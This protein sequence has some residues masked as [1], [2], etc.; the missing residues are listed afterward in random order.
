[1]DK[2]KVLYA[3]LITFLVMGQL[4]EIKYQSV[5][6]N[7]QIKQYAVV[8][9]V[10]PEGAD[11]FIVCPDCECNLTVTDSRDNVLVDNQPCTD[12][13]LGLFT[14]RVEGVGYT[15]GQQYVLNHYCVSATKGEGG[16]N[17]IMTIA[18]YN[19]PALDTFN[20]DVSPSATED[21]ELSRVPEVCGRP[22]EGILGSIDYLF[23]QVTR[24]VEIV[25]LKLQEF[26]GLIPEGQ[27]KTADDE[28][29][30]PLDFILKM[31]TNPTEAI[32]DASAGIWKGLMIL[33]FAIGLPLCFVECFFIYQTVETR[34]GGH[35][36]IKYVDLH[37]KAL[38]FAYTIV[39]RFLTFLSNL[40]PFT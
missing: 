18:A 32:S 17:S 11:Y 14:Y 5:S 10:S 19:T 36:I 3:I 27:A 2:R 30:S 40:V 34:D 37:L 25:I 20:S 24:T 1:M 26:V 38:E 6:Y 8:N 9:E 4:S 28:G 23:C 7:G 31:F 21:D 16:V 29:F 13:G 15:M 12:E 22:V 33:L 35:M 39:I